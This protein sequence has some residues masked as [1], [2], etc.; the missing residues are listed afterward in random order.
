MSRALGVIPARYASTRFPGKPLA[1]L[2]DHTLLEEVWRRTARAKLLERVIVATDDR[3]I[4]DAAEAFGA[5]V[6]LTSEEHHS[7]MDRVAEAVTMSGESWDVVVN[8]QGDEPL[9]TPTSLDR[10]VEAFADPAIEMATLAEP[11]VSREEFADPN[12]VKVVSAHDGRALYFSRSP[13]P[14]LRD[15]EGAPDHSL[16]SCLK[17]QGIYAYR[18]ETLFTLTRTAPSPLERAEGLEQL[19]ALENGHSIVV[20]ESDFRSI[21]VDTPADLQRVAELLG[22]SELHE[23]AGRKGTS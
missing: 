6:A 13:I 10:L 17:H 8:I 16:K 11:L 9:I 7:G 1:P 20:I 19:R 18:P 15:A 3:R 12:V 23:T 4:A 5:T 14:Y 2:G 21:G 22:L